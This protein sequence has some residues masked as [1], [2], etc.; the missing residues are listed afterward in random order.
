MIK[1]FNLLQDN[2]VEPSDE[3]PKKTK[4]FFVHA[5]E[6]WDA[7]FYAKVNDDV[8]VNIGMFIRNIKVP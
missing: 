3:E 7:E 8:Y 1:Q 6:A 5:G 2:H 4:L